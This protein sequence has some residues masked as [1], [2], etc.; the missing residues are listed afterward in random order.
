MRPIAVAGHLKRFYCHCGKQNFF[1]LSCFLTRR[2]FIQMSWQVLSTSNV[3]NI[4]PGDVRILG[5]GSYDTLL[6][7]SDNSN[8]NATNTVSSFTTLVKYYAANGAKTNLYGAGATNNT[9]S[10]IMRNLSITQSQCNPLLMWVRGTQ[11]QVPYLVRGKYYSPADLDNLIRSSPSHDPALDRFPVYGTA[12]APTSSSTPSSTTTTTTTQPAST[13][14]TTSSSTTPTTTSTTTTPSSSSSPYVPL[15]SV[16]DTTSTGNASSTSSG[17]LTP[18]PAGGSTGSV[19][20]T[21]NT[22]L[23]VAPT[24]SS[25]TPA[26]TSERY[27]T[28]NTSSDSNTLSAGSKAGISVGVIVGVALLIAGGYWFY[29]KKRNVRIRPRA[30]TFF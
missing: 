24:S 6:I 7:W 9:L 21:N 3:A 29:V 15:G 5:A 26:P 30:S 27:T 28:T 14:S 25:G 12:P 17:G 13:T 18:I 16:D 8:S 4:G 19:T 2:H 11:I 20:P 23:G 10:Q 22:P 1:V